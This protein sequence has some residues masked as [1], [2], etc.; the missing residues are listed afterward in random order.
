MNTKITADE[1]LAAGAPTALTPEGIL[2]LGLGFW[3]SKTLLS[4]WNWACSPTWAKDLCRPIP[5][6][7]G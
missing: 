2:N 3:A 7:S 5:S 1:P 6:S 4:A